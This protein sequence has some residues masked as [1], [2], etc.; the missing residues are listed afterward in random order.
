MF[1]KI[2]LI[3]QFENVNTKIE[4]LLKVQFYFIF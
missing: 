1:S 2:K 3:L 4:N